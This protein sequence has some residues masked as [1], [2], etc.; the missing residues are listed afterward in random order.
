MWNYIKFVGWA[1]LWAISWIFVRPF[2]RNKTNCLLWAWEK[3][4]NEGGYLVIRWCKV[5]KVGWLKW[6]HFLWLDG[7]HHKLLEH[8]IPIR[9]F[10]SPISRQWFPRPW[11]EGRVVKGDSRGTRIE[12]KKPRFIPNAIYKRIYRQPVI[13]N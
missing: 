6:P 7:K 3:W 4:E 13:E 5:N 10:D 2:K 12:T 9:D 1:I 11:F 8:Y